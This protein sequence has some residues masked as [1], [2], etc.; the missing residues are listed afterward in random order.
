MLVVETQNQKTGLGSR[1]GSQLLRRGHSPAYDHLGVTKEG[2]GGLWQQIPHQG[3]DPDSIVA[4]VRRLG[5]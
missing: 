2:L 3:L 5:S 1:L 4:A